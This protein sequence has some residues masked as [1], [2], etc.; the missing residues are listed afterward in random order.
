MACKDSRATW[1]R[2]VRWASKV[3]L[4]F[5]DQSVLWVSK[6]LTDLKAS[7][8]LSAFVASR[9]SLVLRVC[10]DLL[11]QLVL[12]VLLVCAE[13]LGLSVCRGSKDP[14]V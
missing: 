5:Q 7:L 12:L 14:L 8:V 11:V 9:E 13:R 1:V 2:L 4:V 10:E 3:F 6:V